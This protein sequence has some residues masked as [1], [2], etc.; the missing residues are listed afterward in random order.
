MHRIKAH[1]RISFKLREYTKVK[2]IREK[3]EVPA[4]FRVLLYGYPCS[5]SFKMSN[6]WQA[7]FEHK[8]L[9]R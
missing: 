7:V 1:R 8:Q 9:R 5:I 4:L 2:E 3:G 6:Q